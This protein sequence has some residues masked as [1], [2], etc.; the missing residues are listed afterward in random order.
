MRFKIILLFILFTKIALADEIWM[1]GPM[2]HCN[3]GNHK[4]RCSW[5]IEVSYWNIGH[6]PYSFDAAVEYEKHKIRLYSEAQTGIGFAGVS[7]GPLIEYKTDEKKINGGFQW[8]VWGNYFI[9]IDLRYRITGDKS[10]FCPGIYAKL[11]IK[12]PHSDSNSSY[13]DHD[14]FDWD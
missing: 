1:I 10:Y 7:L 8:S 5:G 11:P 3:F 4:V 13:S 14:L 6:F 2:L 9:G 12:Y